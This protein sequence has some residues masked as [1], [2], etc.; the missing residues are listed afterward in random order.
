MTET[1]TVTPMHET[2]QTA[3]PTDQELENACKEGVRD[4]QSTIDRAR[5]LASARKAGKAEA[6]A[7]FD[8]SVKD[9]LRAI[10]ALK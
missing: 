5:Y 10:G 7:A 9:R 8:R 2:P 6:R 3:E 4:F 1:A